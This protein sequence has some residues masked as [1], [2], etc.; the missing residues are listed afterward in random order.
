[1]EI[2]SFEVHVAD[3]VLDDLHERLQRV[4]WPDEIEDAGWAYGSSLTYMRELVE[5]WRTH[6][7]WRAQERAINRFA[8]YRASIAGLGIHFIH[9]P[10]KGPN[11]L[12]LI[13][14]HGWPGSFFE[15]H[16]LIPMLTDPASY[17]GDAR[18]AF[19]V[20]VPSLPGYGFSDRPTK[21]GMTNSATAALWVRLMSQGLSYSRFAAHGGDIGSGVTARLGLRHPSHLLGIHVT[22]VSTPYLGP[23]APALSAAEREYVALQE[24]WEQEE[25][26]YSHQQ[27]TRPQTLAYGLNDSPVGLASWIIEKFRAWSDCGGAIETR[28]SKDELLTNIMLYWATETINSSIR[29]YAEPREPIQLGERIMVPCA[30]AL[31]REEVDRAPREWAERTY[32]VQRWTD[33]PSGGHFLALEEPALLAE[34]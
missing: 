14:T 8:H 18:D 29:R 34:D 9:E 13:L 25:G 6:F 2:S 10:G 1:M 26:A 15:M 30:I 19:D 23:E 31:T 22:A 28:F 27:H 17:G 21:P 16:K 11:P 32:N 7:D 5:Y 33:M 12:P 4:R 24:R 20:V 3:S